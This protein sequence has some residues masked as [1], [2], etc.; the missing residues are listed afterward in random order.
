MNNSDYREIGVLAKLH[1]FK[2]EYVLVS[3]STISEEIEDWESV[4]IEIDGLPVPFLLIPSGL[5]PKV[6]W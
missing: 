6:L 3:D 1:G 2:G 5:L 4:F